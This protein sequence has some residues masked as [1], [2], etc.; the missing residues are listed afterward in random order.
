L[1]RYASDQVICSSQS[2]ISVSAAHITQD[3]PFKHNARLRRVLATI[4]V[5][6][7]QYVLYIVNGCVCSHRY[8]A[9]N[10]RAGYLRLHT[11]TRYT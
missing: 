11:N 7:K 10:G 6:E 5:V 9:W 4:V 1:Q 8:T 2:Y 3:R